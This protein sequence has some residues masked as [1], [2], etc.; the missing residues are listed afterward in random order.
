VARP[1]GKAR[2]TL[3]GYVALIVAGGAA[4]LCASG[5]PSPPPALVA[6]LFWT[7]ANI[8]CEVLW[9]PA[10]EGRGYLSMATAANFATL[11][12]LPP[13]AAIATTALAGGLADAVFRRRRWYQVLFNMGMTSISVAAASQ[14]FTALGGVRGGADEILSPLNALPLLLAAVTFFLANTWLVAGVVAISQGGSFPDVWRTQFAFN[15]ALLGGVVLLALG[16][17]FAILFLT[18]GYLS[19]FL[20]AATAYFVRDAYSRFIREM[21]DPRPT[22]G[23]TP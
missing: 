9:L 10:P 23:P 19:A 16:W 13:G 12:I 6:L 3:T 1:A 2:A 14:V 5:W 8:L 7:L 21:T 22:L 15:Y 18:W 20:A 17:F 4:A 11:L